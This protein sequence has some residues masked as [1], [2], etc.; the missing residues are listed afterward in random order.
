M[1]IFKL[2]LFSLCALFLVVIAIILIKRYVHNE[3][4]KN[5]IFIVMA[6]I[7]VLIHY[8]AMFVHFY[9]GDFFI[10]DNLFLPVYPCNVM[11]W[12]NFILIFLIG[13]K[14]KAFKILAEFSFW[15]GTIC[16]FIGLCLNK[17]FL[18][19][20]LFSDYDILKGLLSHVT[21]IFC[22]VYL[23]TCGYV[24]IKTIDN[25]KSLLIGCVILALSSFVSDYILEQMGRE[26]VNG[27]LLKPLEETPIA[28]F[29][30]ISLAGAILFFVISTIYESYVYKEEAWFKTIR[31]REEKDERSLN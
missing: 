9:N 4:T 11:M 10:E 29:Y 8:S 23:G 21:M 3:K 1:A 28:N 24:K 6:I 16:G 19:T 14:N 25:F 20:P 2:T 18:N 13:K 5:S 22:S 15:S 17:N 30:C 26:A 7:T 31:K 12:I 27:M